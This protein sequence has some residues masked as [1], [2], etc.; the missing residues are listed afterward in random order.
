[1]FGKMIFIVLVG[2]GWF[3]IFLIAYSK[4]DQQIKKFLQDVDSV[5]VELILILIMLI[6]LLLPLIFIACP[7]FEFIE[8]NNSV[9]NFWS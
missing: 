3:G 6:V 2:L 8:K 4:F 7:I 9:T 5:T 1:M